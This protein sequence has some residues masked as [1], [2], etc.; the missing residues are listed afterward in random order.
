MYPRFAML[1]VRNT[2][3]RPLRTCWDALQEPRKSM[4]FCFFLLVFCDGFV[5]SC[6][7]LCWWACLV[8]VCPLIV[9]YLMSV[10]FIFLFFLMFYVYFC[11]Y[12]IF[13]QSKYFYLLLIYQALVKDYS[14][15]R[16]HVKLKVVFVLTDRTGSHT[17]IPV[18]TLRTANT[19]EHGQS[20]FG[21][22]GHVL[23]DKNATSVT[24]TG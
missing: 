13:P 9:L 20:N 16:K 17:R 19:W 7:I 10:F 3:S 14:I 12:T 6:E 11:S 15:K 1:H 4:K 21:N 23:R 5:S 24:E 18:F 8:L 2:W 22:T